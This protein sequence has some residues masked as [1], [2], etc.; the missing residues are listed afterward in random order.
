MIK[1][2]VILVAMGVTLSGCYM[3]PMAFIGPA[4]SGWTSASIIQSSF[5][6]GA[7]Y[8]LKKSTGKTAGEHAYE[9]INKNILQQS[10]FPKKIDLNNKYSK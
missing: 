7:N 2:I 10:Y 9:A 6:T 8:M 3:V 4:A 1:R 5:T